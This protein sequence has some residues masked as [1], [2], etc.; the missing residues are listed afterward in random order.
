[1]TPRFLVKCVGCVAASSSTRAFDDV[2]IRSLAIYTARLHETFCAN[3][4]MRVAVSSATRQ[5]ETCL[6]RRTWRIVFY[7][8]YVTVARI[9][10]LA[11]GE[12]MRL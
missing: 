7:I 4:V 10:I 11:D 2:V 9:V 12:A 6:K 5:Q 3:D 8:M 1:M